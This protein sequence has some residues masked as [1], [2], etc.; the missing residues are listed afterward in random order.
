M[1][2]HLALTGLLCVGFFFFIGIGVR[3]TNKH[4]SWQAI[5]EWGFMLSLVTLVVAGV[6]A[7]W[8]VQ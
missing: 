3:E 6:L 1:P 7:I 4:T 5:C 8:G 2:G